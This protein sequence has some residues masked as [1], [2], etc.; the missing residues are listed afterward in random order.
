M[1][2]ML[3]K[4]PVDEK[5]RHVIHFIYDLDDLKDSTGLSP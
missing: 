3:K 4:R 1:M 2:E 5:I